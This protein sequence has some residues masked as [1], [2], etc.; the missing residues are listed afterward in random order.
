[1]H[2]RH[3]GPSASWPWTGV[4]VF[5][6]RYVFPPIRGVQA[7]VGPQGEGDHLP[8]TPLVRMPTVVRVTYPDAWIGKTTIRFGSGVGA[9]NEPAEQERCRDCSGELC[10]QE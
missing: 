6:A 2:S 3:D 1:M 10:R 9:G 5:I 4:P 7:G 8:R